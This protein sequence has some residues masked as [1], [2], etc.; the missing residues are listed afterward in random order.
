MMSEQHGPLFL[1]G[2]N[3]R[4]APIEIR[5]KL[6]VSPEKL[7]WIYDGLRQLPGFNEFLVLSTCN[8]VEIYSVGIHAGT[9]ESLQEFF[10]D[11]NRFDPEL[12]SRYSVR[13]HNQEAVRH[14]FEV[15]TGID[16][17][18]VGEA[19]ILGQVKSS[20][21]TAQENGA[22][23]PL[24]NKVVQKSF[25][26]AKWVRTHTAIGEGQIS[27]GTVAVDLALKIFGNLKSCRILVLGAGEIAE[28]TI[29]ALKN[30]GAESV[31]VSNRT[32]SRAEEIALRFDGS[33]LPFEVLEENLADF[34]IVIGSTASEAPI[35]G[36][37][38][39]RKIMKRRPLRPLFLIDLA[40][41]RDFDAQA[42]EVESVFLY[43][44][45]DLS[46]LAERNLDARKA[47]TER[48]RL[49]LQE[50]ADYLWKTLKQ[51]PAFIQRPPPPASLP[52]DTVPYLSSYREKS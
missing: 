17:L 51:H 22:M 52:A 36:D 15:S 23:G 1:L 31:T 8:R 27:V 43:N 45:D 37:K 42:G 24:L 14:L 18:V 4:T 2:A 25:Q 12:F 6:S 11:F 21:A 40:V 41:P 13:M 16:S 30:R 48:C 29:V 28:K 10:C 3:H 38:E 47:E 9:I 39:L 32:L 26:A 7:K 5:E 50:R 46:E 34:D 35:L 49:L 19:E 33:I 20:Y 44:I